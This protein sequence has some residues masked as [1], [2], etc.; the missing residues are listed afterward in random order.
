MLRSSVRPRRVG[1]GSPGAAGRSRPAR[2]RGCRAASSVSAAGGRARRRRGD[3]RG[4]VEHRREQR[5]RAVAVVH[6]LDQPALLRPVDVRGGVDLPEARCGPCGTGRRGSRACGRRRRRS[7]SG[8]CRNRSR[9]FFAPASPRCSGVE[10]RGSASQPGLRRL[11][12]ARPARRCACCSSCRACGGRRRSR[13]GRARC[14]VAQRASRASC[15]AGRRGCRSEPPPSATVSSETI[16]IP[17]RGRN[18]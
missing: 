18:E 11:A 1:A 4:V 16:S 6:H 12:R 3:R 13:A 2:G 10:R 14:G 7:R 9:T 15:T 5:Q 8:T 17:A